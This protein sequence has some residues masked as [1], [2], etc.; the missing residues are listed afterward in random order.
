M[1][2]LCLFSNK[3]LQQNQYVRFFARNS[4][5][6]QLKEQL[7]ILK[8]LFRSWFILTSIFF[9]QSI[10]ATEETLQLPL[11]IDKTTGRVILN[12]SSLPIIEGIT[13]DDKQ[14]FVCAGHIENFNIYFSAQPDKTNK[15]VAIKKTS[16]KPNFETK[17]LECKLVT[18]DYFNFYNNP[19][20][21]FKLGNN[22]TLDEAYSIISLFE[23]S[24][25]VDLPEFYQQIKYT[26]IKLVSKKKLTQKKISVID[27][28]IIALDVETYDLR[29]GVLAC[30]CTTHLEVSKY[31]DD[32][33]QERLYLENTPD[34]IC[35]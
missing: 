1:G 17:S 10:I 26:D 19:V 27:M 15:K 31:S 7:M 21:F 34:G 8:Y 6:E 9:Y 2:V 20:N 24:G 16:C 23:K 14:L 29:F 25:I 28:K 22:T 18:T 35:I 32:G 3:K 4:L 30:G 12:S 33:S 11:E 5:V 13:K